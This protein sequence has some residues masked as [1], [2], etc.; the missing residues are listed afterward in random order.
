[1][2]YNDVIR[3]LKIKKLKIQKYT[4]KWKK[5]AT[6]EEW[7][8]GETLSCV[9]GQSFI[10]ST[11]LQLAMTYASIAN[12]GR[13]YRPYI[14]KEIFS[15]DGKII[16][17]NKPDL[18]REAKIKRKTL[19]IIKRSLY[20]AVNQRKGTAWWYRGRGIQMSG[21]TGTSQVI[22]IGSD[23][24]YSKCENYEYKYRHHGIF[25]SFAPKINPKIAVSVVVEHG[26]HGS[27][28]AAPVAKEVVTT[29]L[30]KYYPELRKR[31]IEKEK[32]ALLKLQK[33]LEEE[34]IK[35]DL[36]KESEISG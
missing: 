35:K 3:K 30:Q 36:K 7:Q 1:M 6:N 26:C 28:A 13:L 9:I 25:V 27:T 22:R 2:K 4:K 18:I 33:K 11:P 5:K 14:I 19:N 23:K 10:L 15:N 24:I 12:G 8:L 29:Y 34:K 16:K 17:K 32:I 21:K 20:Q 31:N